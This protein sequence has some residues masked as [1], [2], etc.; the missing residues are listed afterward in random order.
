MSEAQDT[1]LGATRDEM[2][3]YL[4]AHD[5]QCGARADQL[6]VY[7]DYG[8]L[9]DWR[10]ALDAAETREAALVGAI[11]LIGPALVGY[12]GFK[13]VWCMPCDR[14]IGPIPECCATCPHGA[15]CP[16]ALYD[17]LAASP[18]PGVVGGEGEG[19]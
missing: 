3:H 7:V 5:E 18:A 19:G 17:A 15:H 14:E 10:A 8:D 11:R 16:L 1:P 6:S 4:A 2:V 12:D 13:T 9:C